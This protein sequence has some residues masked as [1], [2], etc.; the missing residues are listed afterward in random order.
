MGSFIS[1]EDLDIIEQSFIRKKNMGVYVLSY[2]TY[3][4]YFF[5]LFSIFSVIRFIMNY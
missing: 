4:R 3:I 1:T 2:Y 5:I